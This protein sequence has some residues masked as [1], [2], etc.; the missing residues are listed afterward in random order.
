MFYS[1]IFHIIASLAIANAEPRCFQIG[2]NIHAMDLNAECIHDTYNYSRAHDVNNGYFNFF[3]PGF[4]NITGLELYDSPRIVTEHENYCSPDSFMF[5]IECHDVQPTGKCCR[6]DNKV[7]VNELPKDAVRCIHD[8]ESYETHF[9]NN[10]ESLWLSQNSTIN[11][12]VELYGSVDSEGYC[13]NFL[14]A[15]ECSECEDDVA[16]CTR[17]YHCDSF[18]EQ[19]YRG[20]N[21]GFGPWDL[22]FF[23]SRCIDGR[24]SRR[25]DCTSDKYCEQF[26]ASYGSKDYYD[27]PYC[28]NG[29]CSS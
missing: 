21:S 7:L 17:D 28:I 8:I 22:P 15:I 13:D 9:P 6:K 16:E 25:L 10:G 18:D 27:Y 11:T 19:S 29:I 23:N 1:I 12:H 2:H 3:I 5:H 20:T 26:G 24:C 14:Y 4:Y